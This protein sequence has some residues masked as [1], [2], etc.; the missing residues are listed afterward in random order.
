MGGLGRSRM[1][2]AGKAPSL[3][4]LDIIGKYV[5]EVLS[6]D[7]VTNVSDFEQRTLSLSHAVGRFYFLGDRR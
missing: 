5:R 7:L 2:Q 6:N 3:H 4:D 1:G